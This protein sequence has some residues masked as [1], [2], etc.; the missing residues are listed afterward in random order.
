MIQGIEIFLQLNPREEKFHVVDDIAEERQPT[1]T[2]RKEE[3]DQTSQDS[4]A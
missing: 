3:L 1:E 4:Q 2:V